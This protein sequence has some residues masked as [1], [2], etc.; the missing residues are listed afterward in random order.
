MGFGVGE[1][2]VI[3]VGGVFNRSEFLPAGDPLT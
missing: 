2:S 3:Y 1:L